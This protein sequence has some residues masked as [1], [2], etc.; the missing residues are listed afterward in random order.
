[1]WAQ[2]EKGQHVDEG[3]SANPFPTIVVV[4]RGAVMT[5][6]GGVERKLRAGETAFV[7]AGVTDEDWNPFDEPAEVVLIMFGDQA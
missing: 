4:V 1:M 7:P 3:G 5:R 2:V 6:I